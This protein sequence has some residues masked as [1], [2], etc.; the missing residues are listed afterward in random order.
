M[1]PRNVVS[2]KFYFAQAIHGNLILSKMFRVVKLFLKIIHLPILAWY[3]P[4]YFLCF[5]SPLYCC[6]RFLTTGNGFPNFFLQICTISISM[7]FKNSGFKTGCPHLQKLFIVSFLSPTAYCCYRYTSVRFWITKRRIY[8]SLSALWE[9]VSLKQSKPANLEPTPLL[10]EPVS[11]RPGRD[12][13]SGSTPFLLLYTRI[14]TLQLRSSI[15]P[16]FHKLK[17]A[18]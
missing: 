4:I 10:Q 6:C 7:V 18:L 14:V 8:S 17:W 12:L 1:R 5:E 15:P 13:T 2:F 11:L 9:P 3:S 16:I